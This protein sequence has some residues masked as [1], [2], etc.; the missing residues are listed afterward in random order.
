MMSNS[1]KLIA[2]TTLLTHPRH[3]KKNI[4]ALSTNSQITSN[5][6][7]ISLMI[8]DQMLQYMV[9]GV[10]TLS[11]SRNGFALH[12]V[13]DLDAL[14]QDHRLYYLPRDLDSVIT[15]NYVRENKEIVVN[16]EVVFS[17]VD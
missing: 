7:P 13:A 6:H 14:E 5:N 2:A 4:V 16:G 10:G 11:R 9:D 12:Q 8:K 15:E 3:L 17:L 1:D